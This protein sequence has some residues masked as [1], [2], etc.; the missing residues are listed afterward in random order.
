[1][2]NSTLL[3][4]STA[5]IFT[6]SALP[7][8]AQVTPSEQNR[9]LRD[10]EQTQ[11]RQENFLKDLEDKQKQ[12]IREKKKP[13]IEISGEIRDKTRSKEKKKEPCFS[14]ENIELK[15]ATILKGKELNKILSTKLDN[16]AISTQN[17][18]ATCIGITEINNL[19]HEVTNYYM[20]KGYVTTRVTVPQQDLKSGKLQ[21]IV[22]EGIVEDI[23]LNENSWRD[24]AQVAM[25]F[26]LMKGRVLNLRDIEQG[27]DQLNRLSSST[28]TMQLVPGEKQGGT[29]VV[30]TNKINKQNRGSIGYDNSG[31]SATGKNKAFA[32]IERDNLLGLGEAWSFNFNE[33][34][35]A[36]SGIK[37]S[38]IYSGNFSLP[39]GYWMFSQN[40]SHSEYLQTIVGVN[41]SFKASGQTDSSISKLERV[42]FRNQN[43]KISLNTALKIKDN[44]SFIEDV[45]STSGTYQL[46][47]WNVGVDYTLRAL[48]AIWS[49]SSTYERGLKA[50]G[51]KHDSSAITT[52]SPHAQFDKCELDASFYKP[53]AIKSA[54]FAWRSSISGQYSNDTL[55]SSERISIGDR[56]TVRGFGESSLS[57]D[58]GV[59]NRNELILNLPQFTTNKYINSVAGNLQPYIGIDMGAARSKGGKEDNG[60]TG[61]GYM[62]GWATGIRNNS[63]YLSFDIAYAEK[64]KSPIFITA[65]EHEV[66]FTLSTKIGF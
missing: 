24:K 50:F 8:Y 64:I 38:E 63:E 48:D 18:S 52:D 66:Y 17:A 34:T 45:A 62:S 44:K 30:I 2:R 27:L 65:K 11:Q 7:S 39:F 61:A 13:Q 31:Q 25:A 21:L 53:F 28:A 9:A 46:T 23:I 6:C 12:K 37:N 5:L 32:T 59:Y 54:N 57:G 56:Y 49:L 42:V 60:G 10:L 43:S 4:L 41:Q 14:I 22:M 51:A 29:K 58:S 1:M 26:P 33:D 16:N 20:D 36:H 40:A 15:G 35:A 55:F 47:I 3:I 19:M